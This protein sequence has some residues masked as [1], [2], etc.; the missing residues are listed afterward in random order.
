MK[1]YS[2][3]AIFFYIGLIIILG[4]IFIL[5]KGW[6]ITREKSISSIADKDTYVD[7]ANAISNYGG[8]NN[9]MT[10][11]SM[12][13]DIREA[14][15]N[16]NFDDKPGDYIRAEI[17]LEFWGV[18]QTMNFT[19]GLIEESW[20]EYSMTWLNKQSKGQI[21]G[22]LIVVSSGVYTIDITSLISIEKIQIS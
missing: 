6:G 3:K 14:Y 16:F 2:K 9:L 20:D 18:S 5:P 15:F 17:S 8:V 1:Y 4:T 10:G 13:G 19:V 21:I 12:F 11:F 7:T 22:N